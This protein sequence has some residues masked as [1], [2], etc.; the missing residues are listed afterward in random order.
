MIV[1][2]VPH[3]NF[4]DPSGGSV[5]YESGTGKTSCHFQRVPIQCFNPDP[6]IENFF[7]GES[8]SGYRFGRLP[9]LKLILDPGFFFIN[10][11]RWAHHVD[12]AVI[13]DPQMFSCGS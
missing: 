8:A 3:S 7:Y 12:V 9:I 5:I 11:F 6:R 10:P 4:S 2:P 1:N 13:S